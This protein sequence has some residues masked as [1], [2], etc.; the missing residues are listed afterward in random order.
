MILESVKCGPLIWPTIEENRVTRPKKYSKLSATEA[1][2]ADC[3]YGSP[4]QSQ[5]YSTNQS[6]TP[7][8]ITSSSNDYL[9]SVHHNVYSPQP[10]ISH[11]EYAPT[12]NQQQ[13]QPE[14]PQLD[15]GLT[16][17]V[18]KQGDDPIDAINHMMSFLSA[19]IISRY[20]TTNTQLRNSSK[21]RQQATINDGRVTL[22]PIQRRQISFAM[23]TTRTYTP[24]TSGSNYGQQQTVICYNCK[25]EGHMSKQCTKPKRKRDDSWF[26]DKVLLVQAQANGQIL[27]EDELAFLADPRISEGQATQ[28]VITHNAAY[29]ADDLDAYN[30]DCDEL[31]ISKV[32]LMKNLSHY[33]S[34]AL[35]KVVQIVLWSTQM[36]DKIMPNNS[37]VK[38]KKTEVE[39]H[40][41]ISSI[42]NNTKSV[43][44]C[45]NSLKSRT[46]NVNA[47][48]ATC[49]K[50]V[51]DSDHFACVTKMSND[52]NV[53]TKKPNV[54]PIST[55]KPNGH[56]NKSVAHPL[57]KELHQKPLPRNPRDAIGCCMRKLVSDYANSDLFPQL[58]NVSPSADTNVP[59]QQ[60]LDLLFGP[61]YDEFFIAGTLSVHKSYSS[62]NNSTQ[63]DTLPLTNL[64][65]TSEP[66]TT[67]NVHAE[68]N[69]NTQAKAEFTNPLYKRS[70]L[71]Q[72]RGNPLTPVQTRQ[73]LA[74]DPE[75]CMFALTV[76]TAESKNIKEAMADSAWIEAMQEELYQFDRL[77]VWKL[78]DKPFGK[79]VI[80]LK[81]LWKNK[82]DEDQ[83][84]IRNKARLVAKGYAQEECIDFEE[85]F[86]PVARFEAVRIFVA[87]VAHKSFLIYQMD[88]KMSFL[89]GPLKEEVYVAQPDGFVDPDHT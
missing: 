22:Q 68:E 1:T 42:S 75:I 73:Q 15:S 85:S 23:V 17:S 28:T 89:N 2:Q 3:D 8:S 76:S 58:Q 71:A 9:S 21:P 7:L 38:D 59:S 27:Y 82:K 10:S 48:Y 14:F 55:R 12:V 78:V 50:C 70:P 51:F 72:V 52:M 6:L 53:R 16:V 4:Y 37:Q 34:D 32:A 83:T 66:S 33:V 81:W 18:F 24:R 46:L 35:A 69:N 65:P 40:P 20:P 84:V 41:R 30:S 79:N 56:A 11:L 74:T 29:Q 54:V 36:K 26:K 62:T 57:R 64:H 60:E 61:L 80:R 47:V 63:Q 43:T 49:G 67:T 77:W 19:I 45:N 39:D 31:N 5:Q 87:Y 25:G 88:V 13:Q 86:A 44:A